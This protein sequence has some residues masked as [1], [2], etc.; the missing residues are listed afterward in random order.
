MCEIIPFPSRDVDMCDDDDIFDF[1]GSVPVAPDPFPG[2]TIYSVDYG[3]AL[4]DAHVP[5]AIADALVEMVKA[6]PEC[7]HR[8]SFDIYE[9]DENTARID[10]CVPMTVVAALVEMLAARAA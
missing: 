1:P 10:A 4:M 6:S 3:R 9:R 5:V 7:Q 8:C 2:L